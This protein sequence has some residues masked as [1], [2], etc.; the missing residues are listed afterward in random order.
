MK[1]AEGLFGVDLEH[2]IVEIFRPY[3]GQ[4]QSSLAR[5]FGIPGTPKNLNSVLVSRILGLDTEASHDAD[6]KRENIMIKTIRL[7]NDG[8]IKEHMSFS[9]INFID[10]CDETWEHST[11]YQILTKRF[12]FV[13]FQ[14]DGFDDWILQKVIFWSMP[15]SDLNEAHKVW[16]RTVNCLK[17]G[18]RLYFTTR[19]TSN[20]LPKATEN[21]VAHVRPHAQNASDTAP[22]PTG[23]EMTK[24]SFWLNRQYVEEVIDSNW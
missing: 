3:Y 23:G 21:R 5:S 19:G 12:M 16:T 8:S 24:Q 17:R 11:F 10:I 18:V 22:L 13:V 6:L 14:S 7:R 1:C 4:S 2:H 15:V 20:D 9:P